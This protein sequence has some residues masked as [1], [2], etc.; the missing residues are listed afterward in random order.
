MTAFRVRLIIATP[1]GQPLFV[2]DS[3]SQASLLAR[4]GFVVITHTTV[5][6]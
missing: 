6:N 5:L 4:C 2:T 1:T 3:A